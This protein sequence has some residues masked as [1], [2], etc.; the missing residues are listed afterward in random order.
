[1]AGCSGAAAVSVTDSPAASVSIA[2]SGVS[3]G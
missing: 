3:T 1:V 2:G